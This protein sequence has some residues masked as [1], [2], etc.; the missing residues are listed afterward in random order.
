MASPQLNI[1]ALAEHVTVSWIDQSLQ[2]P[3]SLAATV[4][5]YRELTVYRDQ[6][7]NPEPI[8]RIMN[9]LYDYMEGF[10]TQMVQKTGEQYV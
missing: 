6:A 8:D 10:A 4:R 5:Q 1:S 9:S 2:A 3:P 7:P